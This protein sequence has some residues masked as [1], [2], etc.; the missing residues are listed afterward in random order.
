MVLNEFGRYTT[1]TQVIANFHDDYCGGRITPSQYLRNNGIKA[2]ELSGL[3]EI[4]FLGMVYILCVPSLNREGTMHSIVADTRN[5]RIEIFDPR[6]NG[7]NK[8]YVSEFIETL[9][10][11]AVLMS[12]H[13][14]EVEIIPV[15]NE[16]R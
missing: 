2:R 10:Q 13:I 15:K 5:S 16:K 12:H 3:R 6:N 11:R 7:R 8:H 4:D 1:I 14:I 9:D